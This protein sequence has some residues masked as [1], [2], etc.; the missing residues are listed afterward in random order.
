MIEYRA[1]QSLITE[2]RRTADGATAPDSPR[3]DRRHPQTGPMLSLAAFDQAALS[4]PTVLENGVNGAA[5]PEE[6]GGRWQVA[7]E[8]LADGPPPAPMPRVLEWSSHGSAA[9]RTDAADVGMGDLLAEA[10][11][12]FQESGHSLS[13][14][15]GTELGGVPADD[16]TAERGTRSNRSTGIQLTTESAERSG[17]GDAL[18]DP[19]LRLPDLTAEPLWRPPGTGRRSAAGD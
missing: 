14:S 18:T 19:E 12:A 8:L 6:P 13:S 2:A 4:E 10:L 15:S 7:R 16:A 5:G 11:A 17:H 3:V 1:E 9:G